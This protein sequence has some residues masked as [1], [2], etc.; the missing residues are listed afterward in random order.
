MKFLKYFLLTIG[1]LGLVATILNVFYFKD[2]SSSNIYSAAGCIYL[3]WIS[4]KVEK[5][6]AQLNSKTR[7][8]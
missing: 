2:A 4:F 8:T 6:I 5:M 3:I 7:S 1:V